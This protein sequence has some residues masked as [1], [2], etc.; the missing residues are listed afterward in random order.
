MDMKLNLSHGKKKKQ[1]EGDGEE[2]GEVNT[3]IL[4]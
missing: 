1:I 4:T 2:G 3:S